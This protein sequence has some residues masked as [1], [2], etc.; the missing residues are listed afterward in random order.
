METWK[1][2]QHFT[3]DYAD[4]YYHNDSDNASLSAFYRVIEL[5]SP[6][7]PPLPGYLISFDEFD[8]LAHDTHIPVGTVLAGVPEGM[9]VKIGGSADGF[10]VVGKDIL[11]AEVRKPALY[12]RGDG[13]GSSFLFSKEIEVVSLWVS[14][15]QWALNND[16]GGTQS[17]TG[18][19]NGET[20]WEYTNNTASTNYFEVTAGSGKLITELIIYPKWVGVDNIRIKSN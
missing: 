15:A 1:D 6:Y 7:Q 3:Q 17:I 20:V 11:P 8:G 5:Y 19:L 18:K 13:S 10:G 4:S 9:T 12:V 14:A 2:L 16:P